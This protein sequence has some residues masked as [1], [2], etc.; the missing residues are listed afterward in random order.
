MQNAALSTRYDLPWKAVISH[1]LRAF[2]DFYFPDFSERV[3]WRKRPRLR[4][5]ELAKLWITVPASLE[6]EAHTFTIQGD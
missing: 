1:A 3:D 5:K 2:L 4:D 6:R